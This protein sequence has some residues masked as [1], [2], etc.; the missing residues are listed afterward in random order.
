VPGP[1]RYDGVPR[2]TVRVDDGV[3]GE[4]EVHYLRRRRVPEPSAAPP[5]GRHRVGEDD[6]LDLVS[7]RF[8]GDPTAF[9]RICDA[10]DA[11]DPDDLVSPDA[12]GTVL[13]VPVPEG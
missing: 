10:N 2:A 1:S 12:V 11:L 6:R 3:G 9:W 5:L 13:V 8:Y 7:A 4:R